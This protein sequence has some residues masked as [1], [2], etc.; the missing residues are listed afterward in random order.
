MPDAAD[1]NMRAAI[2]EKFGRDLTEAEL[3]RLGRALPGLVLVADRIA[4][5]QSRLGEAAPAVA[6]PLAPVTTRHDG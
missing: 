4:W 3:Q 6:F 1:Q 5:W 2:R